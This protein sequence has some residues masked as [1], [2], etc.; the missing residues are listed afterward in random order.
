MKKDQVLRQELSAILKGGNAHMSFADAVS[1]FPL[2]DINKKLPQASYTVWHLL[3]H[4][5]IA[6]WDILDF[7]TNPGYQSLSFPDGYWPRVDE[8]A[9]P[10][11]WKKTVE[12]FLADLKAMEELV[13]DPQT[14]F[15]GPIP[16]AKDYTVFREVLLAA[17]HNAYHLG[18]LVCLRR[19][20]DLKPIKEY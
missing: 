8:T 1:E 10:A 11:Q 3:E 19:V 16:H 18:E 12:G 9:S 4:M 20:L 7:V 15:F 17:D 5:R 2:K 14:D 6:Q 13:K